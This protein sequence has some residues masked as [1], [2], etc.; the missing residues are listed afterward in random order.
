[1]SSD[2][3]ATPTI[4]AGAPGSGRISTEVATLYGDALDR[5][6]AL[7]PRRTARR[8]GNLLRFLPYLRPYATRFVLMVVFA[9]A[10]TVAGIVTPLVT[11]R[12]VDGPIRDSQHRGLYTLGAAAIAIGIVEAVFMF[13]RRWVVA[14]GTL[15]TET[16]IRLDLYAKLQRLP[17][18]FH[19][20]WESGQLLSRIMND[21][22]TV[23]RFLGF[24]LLFMIMNLL[25]IVITTALLL[26]MYWPLGLVVVVSAVPIV[27]LCLV[28]ERQYTRLSR[29]IQ[30]QTG[31]VASAVEESVGGL[32]VIKA[33]GRR[34]HIF[35][36]FD[37][38][39][40]DLWRTSMARVRLTSWFWTVLEAIPSLTLVVVLGFGA[41]AV[42]HQRISLGTL[43]AFI[44]LMLSIVWPIASLGFLLSMTQDSMTAADR[45]SEIFDATETIRDGSL[46]LEHPEGRLTFSDVSFR[47]PDGD[48]D[49]LEHL[50]LEIE[51]GQTI[52]LVGGTGS[53][54]T[55][56]T[57]L[58]PRLADVTGG[59]IRIDGV[60][61]RDLRVAELRSIVATAFEDATLFS[62]SVRENLTLGRSD[63]TEAE[64]VQALDVAQ[65]GFVHDLPWGLDTR[66]G[67]QGMSLSGG[68]RQRLALA[69]AVLV[70]PRI[71]V[72]DDTLSALDMETEALV[73]AALK[74]VLV[75]VTGIVVAH[76]ASTVLLA[77]KV[78]MLSEGRVSHVGTHAEL[79]ATVP[80]Y[81]E[82]LSADY[83]AETG[84]TPNGD[85]RGSEDDEEVLDRG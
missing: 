75:G 80:E 28:N 66:I 37:G 1:M 11:Q 4:S 45:I 9:V 40:T 63:A 58:V 65:A 14:R 78:A 18:G 69:R 74:R 20:Q 68:Q 12:V 46:A 79:L 33:F 29:T 36:G 62:M 27:W 47:F 22:S 23:R 53:G 71:L 39:A 49:V 17:L 21:L 82:L 57:A 13:W 50:N 42:G 55:T 52:A 61:I 70:K 34:E 59:A 83:D 38:R 67:E 85:A 77:D 41:L 25:Q 6:P 54:K 64:I 31:D 26:R 16:G 32:R 24:G 84:I 43:V 73:E 10:S 2:T 5:A 30:D 44:T 76:R 56:L 48:A 19:T 72:L 15:G 81:R 3:R 60:D 8:F 51:P 7:A 35:E